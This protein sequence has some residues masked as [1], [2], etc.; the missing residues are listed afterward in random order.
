MHPVKQ[1]LLVCIRQHMHPEL[2]GAKREWKICSEKRNS[3]AQ[4]LSNTPSSSL[5]PPFQHYRLFEDRSNPRQTNCVC[6]WWP[7]ST[8][9]GESGRGEAHVHSSRHG[10]IP[11][12]YTSRAEAAAA[13]DIHLLRRVWL[14]NNHSLKKNCLPENLHPMLWPVQTCCLLPHWLQ[15]G[16]FRELWKGNA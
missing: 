2:M 6:Y 9:T 8:G 7:F 10:L 3:L 12:T 1:Y 5:L 13:S 16:E 15:R 4:P 11:S 14:H